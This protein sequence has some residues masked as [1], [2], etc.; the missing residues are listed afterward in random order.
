MKK[1]RE[2]RDVY[3]ADSLT[4][5]LYFRTVTDEALLDSIETEMA[6]RDLDGDNAAECKWIEE[7]QS[8][9]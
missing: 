4:L 2:F 3:N 1:P 8:N 5:I 9:G 7:S 6:H